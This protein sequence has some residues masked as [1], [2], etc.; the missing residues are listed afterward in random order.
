MPV[1]LLRE[2][3]FSHIKSSTNGMRYER[4]EIPGYR[5]YKRKQ[6]EQK[7]VGKLLVTRILL[8]L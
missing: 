2:T 5:H 1:R 4:I 7:N 3:E 6:I 8:C